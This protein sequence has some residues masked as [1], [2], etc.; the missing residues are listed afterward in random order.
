MSLSVHAARV[1]AVLLLAAASP[2]ARSQ[3]WSFHVTADGRSIGTHTFKVSGDA[4]NRSVQTTAVF[5][6]SALRI[7]I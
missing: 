7:P 5:K 6:A 3:E 1:S 2:A 4:Q